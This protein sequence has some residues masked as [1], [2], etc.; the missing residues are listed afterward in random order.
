MFM[1]VRKV[2]DFGG[3]QISEFQIRDIQPVFIM[4]NR[5]YNTL[6]LGHI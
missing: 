3:F 1:S 5:N 2:W 6:L 4:K